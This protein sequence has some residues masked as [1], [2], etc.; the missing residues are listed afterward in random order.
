MNK[1]VLQAVLDAK[2]AYE[3]DE[4]LNKLGAKMFSMHT[5]SGL[6][7]DMFMTE[8]SKHIKLGKLAKVY[9]ISVYQEKF[10]EH[11]R[12]S[13]SEEKRLD[14]LRKLNRDNMANFLKSGELGV[15]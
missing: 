8:I 7:P 6:P 5:A 2:Q 12:K 10:L 15:Y 3:D 9:I 1:D 14:K 11:R 13:G 4:L